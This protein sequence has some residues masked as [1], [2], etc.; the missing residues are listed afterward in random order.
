[1][2]TVL[3]VE[4]SL[5]DRETLSRRLQSSGFLVV[6]ATSV[7]EA[8]VKVAQKQP[9]L[10]FLDVI[11]PGQSGFEFCRE[12]KTNPNT[13]QIP[14][15]I[16]STKGTDVDKTWGTMLGADEYLTKPLADEAL[17]QVLRRFG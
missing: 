5:T 9:D 10:I 12:L 13:K 3:V 16:C 2:K 7:E 6:S 14:V 17:Q 4:D 11:L 8:Q 15:V 1:M